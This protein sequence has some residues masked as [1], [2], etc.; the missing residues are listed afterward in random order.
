MTVL[1]ALV[2]GVGV[3]MITLIF[4][5]MIVERQREFGTLIALGAHKGL[6][7]RIVVSESV[8]VNAVGAGL[9]VLVS[10]VLITSFSGLVRQTIGLGFLIPSLPV[11][12]SLA[13]GT[14]AAMGL[15]ALVSSWI[16][17]RALNTADA[18]ALLKEGE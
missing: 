17:L 1:V 15:V 11:I 6:V 3:A 5:L 8:A 13:A 2:W 18:S 4:V 9:G 14:V 16:A 12:T 7:A 10:G